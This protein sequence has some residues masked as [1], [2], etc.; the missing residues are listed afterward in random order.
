[1]EQDKNIFRTVRRKADKYILY[2]YMIHDNCL[3]F[4]ILKIK[5]QHW[6]LRPAIS[7]PDAPISK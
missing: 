1:M 6:R 7:T 3:D 2:R 4:C 5:R